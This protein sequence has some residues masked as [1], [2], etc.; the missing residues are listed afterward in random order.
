VYNCGRG[1]YNTTWLDA[2]WRPMSFTS[3]REKCWADTLPQNWASDGLSPTRLDAHI[4]TYTFCFNLK[5]SP[6]KR[7]KP[8]KFKGRKEDDLKN[9]QRHPRRTTQEVQLSACVHT[10]LCC[11]PPSDRQLCVSASWSAEKA[12]KL[13]S[14][15]ISTKCMSN[16]RFC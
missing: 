13:A 9:P 10:I 15:G 1:S 7:L 6:L 11:L 8:I 14:G 3:A 2:G 4:Y 12:N 5:M 16:V